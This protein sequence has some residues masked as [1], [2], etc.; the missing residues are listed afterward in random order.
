[1]PVDLR[2]GVVRI[3]HPDGT[4]AGTG[5]VVSAD[6]LI[7]T[8]SHVVQDVGA[9]QRGEPRP[10]AVRIVFAANGEERQAQVDPDCWLPREQGDVAFLRLEGGL[11]E[12]VGVLPLGRQP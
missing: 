5:F 2:S 9:Q 11:P 1:M 4:T 7:A 8:C 3:L 10:E 6:G 12:G